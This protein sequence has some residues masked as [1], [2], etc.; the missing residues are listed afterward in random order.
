MADKI[1][2]LSQLEE[3]AGGDQEFVMSMVD[4]FLEHTPQQLQEMK[5]ARESG[6]LATVGAVAHKIKPNIDLFGLDQIYQQIR[7]IER[8]G[9]EGES[10]SELD[11][12]ITQVEQVLNLAFEQLRELK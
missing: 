3:L 2:N 5:S 11:Q 4:T 12:N 6:D 1:F 7:D 8:M 9:K 10:G